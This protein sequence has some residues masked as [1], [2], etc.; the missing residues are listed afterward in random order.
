MN[1]RALKALEFDRIVEVVRSLALTPLGHARLADLHPQRDSRQVEAAL[2][3][4]A[5]MVH[6]LV[7]R[8]ALPLEA[9]SNIE[10][11]LAALA[12]EGRVLDAPELLG[13]A[14]FLASIELTRKAIGASAD[15]CPRLGAIVQ[16]IASFAQETD[17]IRRVIQPSGELIDRASPQLRGIR[18]RLRK[19]RSRLRSTLESYLRGKDTARYLQ[20]EIVTD[21]NGRYVLLVKSEHR[22][23][24]PGIV[25]GSSTSG[26]TLYLEPLSTVEINNE[27]V[28]LEQREQE[29]IRR[30]LLALA[31]RLRARAAD[32]SRA[33]AAAS[34]L[35]VLQAKARLAEI[36]GASRPDHSEAGQIDLRAARHPLL[37]PAVVSRSS[38]A[39]GQ[40]A[41]AERPSGEPV[42]VDIRLEP[43]AS[44]LVITG[45]NTG[46]KTVALKTVGL[47]ALMAQAG[48]LVPAEAGSTLPV[49]RSIFADIGDEQSIAANLSTFSWHVTN[50]AS[51][52][53]RLDLPALV[54]LDEIGA[55]TDP[56]E[57]SALGM[58][59]IDHFRARGALV[60]ATTHYDMLK[61]YAST[62]P[63]VQSAAFGFDPDGFVP[64]YHLIYGS[65]GRS[66][67]LE[68]AGRLGLP[69]DIIANARRHRSAKEAQLAAHLT[70]IE[71]QLQQV[72]RDQRAVAAAT[73]RAS[74]TEAALEE[75]AKT[76]DEREDQLKR[77]FDDR[78]GQRVRD[79][80]REI[81]DVVDQLKRQASALVA[82]A[83]QG[84]IGP[85]TTGDTGAVRTGAQRAL[86]EIASRHD[87][88]TPAT[89]TA[90]APGDRATSV[91]L[92]AP[93]VGQ[94][95]RIAAL[96]AE[97]VLSAV[98]ERHAEVNVRGKRMRVALDE[99]VPVEPRAAAPAPTHISVHLESDTPRVTDLNLIGCRVD[100][101]QARLD[102]FLDQAILAE[103]QMVR[104]I[105]GHGTGRLR[106]AV[107]AFL[108]EHPLVARH[109]V[110][111]SAEGG[112]GV[113]VV[114]L[115]D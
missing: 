15:E 83:A 103:A 52:D 92:D 6:Y 22:A 31:N 100:E 28:A 61:S 53:R 34:E 10:A 41:P 44:A 86:D 23:A 27:V 39:L 105:H 102:K 104:I 74:D 29:E 94:R 18:E 5:E 51:M 26:A 7:D 98:G 35:D 4:T 47:L 107:G 97:G 8:P 115:K 62:T 43:P 78:I 46:G 49:F 16:G 99:L 60:I 70:K 50:I 32:L 33:L 3:S 82:E 76:L 88:V 110:A 55:G 111:A 19:Q 101:A 106:K 69:A 58:A 17:E 21:R 77:R 112:T 113:T 64:T 93:T 68:I 48:L 71:E 37:I 2:A 79:A 9:P 40:R 95:V 90:T 56:T 65:P 73:Q 84:T 45:P 57:G 108:D 14:D 89:A 20:D 12:V 24:I 54:L 75:K 1:T 91:A 87:P 42:P 67:A 96:S 59:V 38:S 36:M 81:D 85:L 25:H 13:T 72:E 30:I 66:L 114:E 11:S 109:T 63:G 80:R